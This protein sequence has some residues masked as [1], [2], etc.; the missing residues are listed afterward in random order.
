MSDP[1][2]PIGADEKP[3]GIARRIVFSFRSRSTFKTD[4]LESRRREFLGQNATHGTHAN[5]ADVCYGRSERHRFPAVSLCTGKSTGL[6]IYG[7]AYP[8]CW[9]GKFTM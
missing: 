4:D 3:N 5:D 9:P 8:N 6:L 7:S 1:V 2:E